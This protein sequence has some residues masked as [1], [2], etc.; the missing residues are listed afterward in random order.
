MTDT[1]REPAAPANTGR[2]DF[3][4]QGM[5]CGSC[6]VRVQRVL[7][8]QPGVASAEVNF[9]TGKAQV[10]PDG[11]VDV[12]GLQAAV[13][14]I[15]YRIEPVGSGETADAEAQAAAAWR[16][17]LVVAV[18]LAAAL[19]ALAMWPGGAMEEPWGRLAALM[20]ATPVQFWVGWPFLREAARRA[21]RRTA[22]MDTLIAMGTWPPTG[23]Q[24]PSWSRGAWTC[25]SRP[26]R[27]SSP[28]CGPGRY[29][30]ARAKGRAGQAIRALLELG[31][32]EARV[33]RGDQEVM[34]P[35]EQVV[36]GDLL[37]VR[38][39][40]KVPTDGEVVA[41]ASAI[42]ESM[43]T[44]ESVPVEKAEGDPVTGPR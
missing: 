42:D 1:T 26:P 28:S 14:R 16:R 44:G 33:V 34:V 41:G 37:R 7:G 5:T 24:W 4:V 21:R 12:G 25:T 22:N 15:G 29:F 35:V 2:L 9:A 19:V 38:P 11:A 17:R 40:E 6:A 13:E 32:K 3:E 27:S 39:G 18:P 10:A 23:S 36:A 43:L 8:R 30:E 20:L 31:A